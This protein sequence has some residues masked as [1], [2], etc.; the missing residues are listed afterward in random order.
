MSNL[1]IPTAS[2]FDIYCVKKQTNNCTHKHTNKCSWKPHPH[3]RHEH[4]QLHVQHYYYNNSSK[5]TVG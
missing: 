1:A 5:A 2:V 3:D 4:P